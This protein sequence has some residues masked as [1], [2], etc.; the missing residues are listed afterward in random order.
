MGFGN[1][2]LAANTLKK[3][4]TYG[5]PAKR[6]SKLDLFFVLL[7][8][9][10][11]DIKNVLRNSELKTEALVHKLLNLPSICSCSISVNKSRV[12]QRRGMPSRLH[13]N[14]WITWDPNIA[15]LNGMP[16]NAKL[17][18]PILLNSFRG[19]KLLN[20]LPIL[21]MECLK[22]LRIVNTSLL[23]HLTRALPQIFWCLK[24]KTPCRNSIV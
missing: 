3:R 20:L 24:Q 18:M 4:K 11:W 14:C 1:L 21:L 23:P 12:D 19:S 9:G 17:A 16:C 5:K 2:A 13:Q 7:F 8:L 6:Q 15:F 22:L 10:G